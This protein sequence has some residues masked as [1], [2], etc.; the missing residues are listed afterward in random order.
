MAETATL[1]VA[2]RYDQIQTLCAFVAAAARR[3]G[4][5]KDDVFHLELCCDEAST[6]IIEHAYGAENKG[7]ISVTYE[8]HQDQFKVILRDDGR[9][10]DPAGVP[11]PPLL[12][13][14]DAA[15]NPALS[16]FLDHLQVGGLGIYFMRE[17]MDEVIYEFDEAGGNKLVLIKN[18]EPGSAA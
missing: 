2:G 12:Q 5:G 17:L 14:E 9:P 16:D 15:Q 13:Q 8:A 6:N 3:A 4:L 1:Q 18:I 10:F 7:E 11:P